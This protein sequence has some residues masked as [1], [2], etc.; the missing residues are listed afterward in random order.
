MTIPRR[1]L[2]IAFTAFVLHGAYRTWNDRPAHPP[3]GVLVAMEPIQ[4]PIDQTAPI[5]AGRWTI[6][7]RAHYDITARVLGRERYRFDPMADLAPVDL[8]LGWGPMSDNAVL[9][10]V[11]VEQSARFYTLR[12]GARPPLEPAELLRHSA[13]THVIP[14]SEALAARLRQLRPG[15]VVHLV[16]VLVDAQR[17]D[18]GWVR[19]S[20]R[21]DDTGDGACE[22]MRVETVEVLPPVPQ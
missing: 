18:G 16:G 1:L 6:I 14:A 8:A 17:S 19:T 2:W 22:V 5:V 12:W 11:R 4:T 15:E 7:P 3:G 10:E 21:R 9:R 20:L 13:N